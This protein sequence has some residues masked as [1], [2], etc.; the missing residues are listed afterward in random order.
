METRNT[1]ASGQGAAGSPLDAL[2]LI[3]RYLWP[4]GRADLKLRLAAAV[5]CLGLSAAV[6]AISQEF[7]GAAVDLLR[8]QPD[9]RQAIPVLACVGAYIV[10]RI[11]M[12]GLAQLRDGVFSKVQNHVIREVAVATFGHIMDLPLQFHLERKTGALSWTVAR[13]TRAIETILTF[14]VFNTIP[15]ILLCIFYSALLWWQFNAW[16]ALIA[17]VT[18]GAYVAFTFATNASRTRLRR[19]L[20][21][22]DGDAN[23]RAVDALLN[24]ETVRYFGNEKLEVFRFDALRRQYASFSERAQW[25]LC[26]LNTGQ[27]VIFTAGQG[28]VLVMTALMV[29]RGQASLGQFVA[30]NLILLQLYQPLFLL[31]TAYRE[32]MQAFTDIEAM[33][34]ILRMPVESVGDEAKP[35]L[36]AGRGEIIFDNV[37]FGYPGGPLLLDGVSFTVPAGKT[38]A[39]VGVSGAGKTTI[40]RL[41]YRMHDLKSGRI[42]IDGQDISNVTRASCRHALGMVPQ[43]CVLFNDTLGFNIRYGHPSCSQDDVQKAVREAQLENI[44]T[45]LPAGAETMVGERGL[46]LSGGE[47]QRVGI[48]RTLLKQPAILLLDEPTSALDARTEKD[49][50]H[51]LD[52]A[53]RDR[54]TIII[55]HRLTTI[56]RADRIVVL[57]DGEIVEHGTHNELLHRNGQYAALWNKQNGTDQA[58][59]LP[60][61]TP[62]AIKVAL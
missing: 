30:A 42:L 54:S 46:K 58:D 51:A 40:F 25:A 8:K 31:G 47:R 7:L 11:A 29:M 14:A 33:Q 23:A 10:A 19:D 24:F 53:S 12:Q 28:T 57:K 52:T 4:R 2:H 16:I 39:V 27:I 61:Y 34:D 5:F 62:P 49:L 44:L 55:A 35:D 41:L 13:G 21:A 50:L 48:A 38:V 17:A 6:T 60:D 56:A 22:K 3:G 43:D 26:G 20:N 9:L 32:I 59:T 45:R 15:T 1:A 37:T 36:K 18:V